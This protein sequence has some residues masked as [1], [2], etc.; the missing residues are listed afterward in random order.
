MCAAI[1]LQQEPTEEVIDG[2]PIGNHVLMNSYKG[3]L[4]TDD[5]PFSEP[6]AAAIGK[7]HGLCTYHEMGQ[8]NVATTGQSNQETCRQDLTALIF[9]Y[10]SVDE[11]KKHILMCRE[12]YGT[13]PQALSFLDRIEEKANKLCIAYTQWYFSFNHTSTQRGE[14]YNDR[15]KGHAD[16]KAMLSDADLVTL[17]N[18]VKAIEIDVGGKV[19]KILMKCRREEKRVAPIYEQ[20]VE[21]SLQM[22]ALYVR[23][24]DKV[25]GTVSEYKVVRRDSTVVVVN[26]DT[27]IVHRGQVFVIPTCSCGY[28]CSSFRICM[29]IAKALIEDG[30]VIWSTNNY[31]PVHLV[32]LHPLWSDAIRKCKLEDYEDLPQIEALLEVKKRGKSVVAAANTRT[33]AA[34]CPNEF[35]EFK[36]GKKKVPTSIKERARKIQQAASALVKAAVDNG[37][38]HT[39]QLGL[40][41]VLQATKECM[42]MTAGTANNAAAYCDNNVLPLPPADRGGTRS[43]RAKSDGTNH[44]RLNNASSSSSSTTKKKTGR[45]KKQNT[46]QQQECAK[47]QLLVHIHKHSL[48]TQHSLETC[49]NQSI[50]D[51]YFM[52]GGKSED[53]L[54]EA[55]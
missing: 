10:K 6:T 3:S 28:W 26:L 50:F 39:F 45:K 55:V 27:K 51:Q 4:Y 29:D 47:C 21:K 43:A 7:D 36:K 41:R 15:L 8:I 30:R 52:K 22:S 42:D 16:L 33:T 25:E 35:Y 17:H 11:L 53:G 13:Q 19:L 32:Q 48:N 9:R 54:Q 23:S 24:C 5:G 44:S 31:H 49:P 14:G 1:I 12:K 38:E 34:V 18:H 37:D 20:A 40:A 2:V 46:T